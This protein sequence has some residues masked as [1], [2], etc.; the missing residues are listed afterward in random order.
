[1]NKQLGFDLEPDGGTRVPT[2]ANKLNW[3]SAFL[4]HTE[5]H[6]IERTQINF[7]D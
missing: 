3:I 4:G 6:Q 5:G 7:G 2:K 1:M